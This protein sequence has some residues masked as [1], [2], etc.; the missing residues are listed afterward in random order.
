MFN[1]STNFEGKFTEDV[2]N[3]KADRSIL[4]TKDP[5]ILPYAFFAVLTS[6]AFSVH[7]KIGENVWQSRFSP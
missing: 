6:K 5:N 4:L 3:L 7:K 2:P 1:Q